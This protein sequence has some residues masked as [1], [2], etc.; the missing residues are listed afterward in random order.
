M[1]WQC[2]T[3][4][5][6][7]LFD[8]FRETPHCEN[9]LVGDYTILSRFKN[10]FL[11]Q[12]SSTF[13]VPPILANLYSKISSFAEQCLSKGWV[14]KSDAAFAADC[15]SMAFK[16]DLKGCQILAWAFFVRANQLIASQHG[17]SGS[18]RVPQWM[19]WATDADTFQKI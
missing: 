7:F 18:G 9:K 11:I 8:P 15:A 12:I 10:S 2:L 4:I 3:R 6:S 5:V 1:C 16:G 13:L 19:A 14:A 17:A